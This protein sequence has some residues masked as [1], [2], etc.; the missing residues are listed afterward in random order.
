MLSVHQ[1]HPAPCCHPSSPPPASLHPLLP[2][3]PHS[4]AQ[5]YKHFLTD[6]VLRDPRQRRFFKAKDLTDLFTLGDEY[7]GGWSCSAEG[8]GL[9]WVGGSGRPPA[10]KGLNKVV[11]GE[12]NMLATD[13]V[14]W[15]CELCVFDGPASTPPTAAA[16]PA[17][18][19]TETAS[20]FATLGTDVLPDEEPEAAEANGEERHASDRDDYSSGRERSPQQAQQAQQGQRRPSSRS[21]SR[22]RRSSSADLPASA[23][24]RSEAVAQEEGGGEAA[25]GSGKG[26]AKILRELFEGSDVRGAIDHTKVEGEARGGCFLDA[27]LDGHFACTFGAMAVQCAERCGLPLCN[28]HF[29]QQLTL[30]DPRLPHL[31][32]CTQAPTTRS[33]VPLSRRRLALPSAPPKRCGSRAWLA[34]RRPSTSLPGLA[35]L[36]ALGCRALVV[37]SRALGGPPT[38]AWAQLPR[39]SRRLRQQWQQVAVAAVAPAAALA[40]VPQGSGRPWLA[41]E[42]GQGQPTVRHPAAHQISLPACASGRRQ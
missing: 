37:G 14:V 15:L 10:C 36:A 4:A 12:R 21:S 28:A 40:G 8:P 35:A 7:A 25:D 9:G 32:P 23:G 11:V 24:V 34:S 20:L 31:T 16:R 26:D 30:N 22:S 19:G 41:Q 1:P 17:A 5:V 6:K 18:D 29:A 27:S 33:D 13:R 39:W 3:P 42:R 2:P 38:H